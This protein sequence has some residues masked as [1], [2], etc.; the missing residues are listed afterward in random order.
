GR[1]AEARTHRRAFAGATN[2]P[3]TRRGRTPTRRGRDVRSR[4]P[5]HSCSRG[6]PCLQHHVY[7]VVLDLDLVGHESL[8]RN[9]AV[10]LA[11]PEHEFP[12]MPGTGHD[13]RLVREGEL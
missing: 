7:L 12:A 6:S 4:L 10:A 9:A 2:G 3:D 8:G 11:G 1:P 13:Q 5:D